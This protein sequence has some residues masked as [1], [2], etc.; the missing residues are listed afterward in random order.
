MHRKHERERERERYICTV[1]FSKDCKLL[2]NSAKFS[3]TPP[4]PQGL[5]FNEVCKKF[6]STK[7]AR[8]NMPCDRFGCTGF[9]I[10]KIRARTGEKTGE[11]VRTCV[12]ICVCMY[13]CTCTRVYL[14]IYCYA[15]IYI[16]IHMYTCM[17]TLYI[18]YIYIYIYINTCIYVT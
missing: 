10:V 1:K 3:I 2:T 8:C 16:Y 14:C 12:C 4:H 13:V 17:C 15:S 11:F 6:K 18:S 7:M 5:S 9:C